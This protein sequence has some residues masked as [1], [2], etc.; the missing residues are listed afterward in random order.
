MSIFFYKWMHL[1]G[2]LILFLALGGMFARGFHGG[3]SGG[4]DRSLRRIGGATS[5]IGLLLV[6]TSGFGIVGKAG[7]GFEGWIF[8]KIAIWLILGGVLLLVSRKRELG[9]VLWWVVIVLGLSAAYLAGY[10]PG[11]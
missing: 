7:L 11:L 1:S 9:R 6:L 8:G 3:E 10:K 5:G 4:D 2:G